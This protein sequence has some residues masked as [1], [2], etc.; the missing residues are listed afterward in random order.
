[1]LIHYQ[2]KENLKEI[3]LNFYVKSIYNSTL[4]E[5][6][7]KI[8]QNM[9]TQNKILS[10]LIDELTNSSRFEK[11]IYLMFLIKFI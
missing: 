9:I 4:S 1:M 8:F 7:Y 10:I 3:T 5:T 11:H 6:F 2:K